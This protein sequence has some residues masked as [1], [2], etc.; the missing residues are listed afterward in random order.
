VEWYVT[1]IIIIII[2]MFHIL[3]KPLLICSLQVR[4]RLSSTESIYS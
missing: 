3:F 1:E 4:L 2:I